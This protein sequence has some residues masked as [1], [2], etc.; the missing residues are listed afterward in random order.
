MYSMQARAVSRL[1]NSRV[2][3]WYLIP[4]LFVNKGA[5][6][7]RNPKPEPWSSKLNNEALIRTFHAKGVLGRIGVQ[8]RLW[9][10][11]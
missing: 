11:A 3:I 9:L 7:R 1:Q 10:Q 5:P 2:L 4:S 6:N 8:L